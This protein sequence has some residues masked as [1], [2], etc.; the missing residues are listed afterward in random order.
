MSLI[1]AS[2]HVPSPSAVFSVP[3][4]AACSLDFSS[5]EQSGAWLGIAVTMLRSRG[6]LRPE[7]RPKV[8]RQAN[9]ILMPF[10]CSMMISHETVVTD[11]WDLRRAAGGE[12]IKCVLKKEENPPACWGGAKAAIVQP[13]VASIS[14]ACSSCGVQLHRRMFAR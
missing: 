12:A 10:Q 13:R 5:P 2:D 7:A 8:Q 4:R 14:A 11:I 9:Q 6:D 3:K 1:A